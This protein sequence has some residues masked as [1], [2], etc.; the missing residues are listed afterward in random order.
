MEDAARR[1]DVTGPFRLD[2]LT[3]TSRACRSSSGSIIVPTMWNQVEDSRSAECHA[4][5]LTILAGTNLTAAS[6]DLVSLFLAW[7]SVQHP[8]LHPALPPRADDA[9]R[10]ATIKYF[11][12]AALFVGDGPLGLAPPF[13][14]TEDDESRHGRRLPPLG[15]GGRSWRSAAAS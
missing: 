7:S 11:L 13:W 14:A 2:T 4:C 1:E 10:E 5:L 12:L 15:P 3:G 9:S 8:D 6:N